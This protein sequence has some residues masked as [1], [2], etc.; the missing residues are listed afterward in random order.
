MY[1]QYGSYTH[2]VAECWFDLSKVSL[3]SSRNRR[4]SVLE[5]WTI[6][7]IKHAAST[8]ALTTALASLRSAY[9]IDDQD[10]IFYEDSGT[11]TEHKLLVSETLNGVK[12]RR[13]DYLPGSTGGRGPGSGDEYVTRRTFRIVIEAEVASANAENLLEYRESVR[14]IGTGGPK[15]VWVP[16]LTGVPQQQV[17]QQKTTFRAIQW[18]YAKGLLLAPTPPT[19]LFPSS[20]W[21]N[22]QHEGAT[23]TAERQSPF[24][25]TGFRVDWKYVAESPSILV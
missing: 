23:H 15:N 24:T 16:S 12:V 5:R 11:Q 3:L 6:Y 7:G 1:L 25:D 2:D 4:R 18:G 17:L 20:V 9:A 10:L 21:V 13:L 14:Q 19:P 22:E 8:S